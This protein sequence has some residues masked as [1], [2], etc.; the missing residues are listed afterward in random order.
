MQNWLVSP[1]DVAKEEMFS[2]GVSVINY[3]KVTDLHLVTSVINHLKKNLNNRKL[4]F[5]SL[6]TLW[7]WLDSAYGALT[8]PELLMFSQSP[9]S[10]GSW[11]VLHSEQSQSPLSNTEREADID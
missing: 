3:E 8:A 4:F 9:V 11:S 10:T 7:S 6:L 2:Q 1:P 5:F